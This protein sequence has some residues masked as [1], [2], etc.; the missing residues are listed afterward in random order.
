VRTTIKVGPKMCPAFVLICMELFCLIRPIYAFFWFFTIMKVIGFIIIL[1]LLPKKILKI[2]LLES[3]STY[4]YVL[5]LLLLLL[6]FL[7]VS[8]MHSM[9]FKF[10]NFILHLTLIREGGDLFFFLLTWV[11]E[12]SLLLI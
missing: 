10:N 4:H 7:L 9:D 5:F 3:L 12:V 8:Y 11:L 2:L 6:S 1:L